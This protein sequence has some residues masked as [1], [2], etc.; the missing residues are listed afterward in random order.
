MIAFKT[1]EQCPE[2]LRPAGIPLAYPWMESVILDQQHAESLVASGFTLMTDD[3]YAQYRSNI[4]IIDIVTQAIIND[5]AFGDELITEFSAENVILGISELGK[6]G[7]I[8]DILSPVIEALRAGSLIEA[9]TRAKEIS[10][11][12]YDDIFITKPRLLIFINKLED[13][14]GITLTTDF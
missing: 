4:V 5:T 12:S 8:L 6:T 2:E 3:Q 14:L 1:F 7:D 11:A 9:I 10:L 13:H